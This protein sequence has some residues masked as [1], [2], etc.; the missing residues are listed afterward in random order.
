MSRVEV[1]HL[2]LGSAEEAPRSNETVASSS[3][4][5]QLPTPPAI[6]PLLVGRAS[7]STRIA[8]P[9]GSR[10]ALISTVGWALGSGGGGDGG[11]CGGGACGDGGGGEPGESGDKGGGGNGGGSEGGSGDGGGDDGGGSDGGGLLGAKSTLMP[12]A[13]AAPGEK[14]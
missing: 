10:R 13:G 9:V 2:H 8:D 6:P 4:D 5:A 7:K 12:Q 1:G 11:N 3:S 14:D